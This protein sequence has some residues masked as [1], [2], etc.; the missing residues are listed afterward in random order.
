MA[1]RAAPQPLPP[2]AHLYKRPVCT[3][4]PTSSLSG[5][6][7]LHPFYR[8]T[9]RMKVSCHNSQS[10]WSN[11]AW[12]RTPGSLLWPL[13]HNSE[14]RFPVEVTPGSSIQED[15]KSTC[16]PLG[17]SSIFYGSVSGNGYKTIRS[18]DKP[19]LY[20]ELYFVVG[21]PG[22]SLVGWSNMLKYFRT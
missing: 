22:L 2:G 7:V 8:K 15:L 11:G 9:G 16:F 19:S 13:N 3:S 4:R 17:T 21:Q 14:M 18:I 12:N 10:K 1:L 5:C 6:K 20:I